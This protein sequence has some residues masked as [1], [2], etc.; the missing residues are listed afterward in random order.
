MFKKS[1]SSVEGAEESIGEDI[2]RKFKS[3]GIAVIGSP[4]GTEGVEGELYPLKDATD[5]TVTKGGDPGK[6]VGGP[7]LPLSTPKGGVEGALFIRNRSR[8]E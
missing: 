1:V 8:M 5:S 6:V 7:A 3:L 2:L 4:M